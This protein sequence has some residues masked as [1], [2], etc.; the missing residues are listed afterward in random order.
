MEA[1][2][3]DGAN[4]LNRGDREWRSCDVGDVLSLSTTSVAKK[5]FINARS[6]ACSILRRVNSIIGGS[7]M[8]AERIDLTVPF[9]LFSR[10]LM[11]SRRRSRIL[12]IFRTLNQKSAPLDVPPSNGLSIWSASVM[13][14]CRAGAWSLHEPSV[15]RYRRRR[16]PFTR[17]SGLYEW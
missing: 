14:A 6:K 13:D 16:G 12:S 17:P 3:D 4:D 5:L 7:R 9:A 15:L 1:S 10:C 11:S 8:E 2:V